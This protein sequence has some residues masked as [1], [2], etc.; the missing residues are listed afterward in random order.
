M[1]T[2]AQRLPLITEADYLEGEQASDIR[3][4]YLGGEVH[5]MVGATDRHGLL[6]GNF[7]AALH[8]H[9]RH[10]P[11]CQVFASDMKVRLTIADDTYF[12]YPDI[13]VS[14][15]ADD[16]QRL[17]REHPVVLVEVLSETTERTDRRE[18]FFAYQTIASLREYV[19][20]AQDQQ[21]LTLYRRDKGWKMETLAAGDTLTL[22][23]LEFSLPVAM[24]Y[25]GVEL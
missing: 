16:R 3:H 24:L 7:F 8:Q 11:P 1:D 22:P 20:V 6:T 5:A 4:E 13:L 18:K 15:R 2:S 10:R 12:Y 23:S 17:Y 19:L 21:Q 9:L 14:C 25:E